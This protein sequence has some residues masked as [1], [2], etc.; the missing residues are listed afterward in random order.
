[1]H[2]FYLLGSS[3]IQSYLRGSKELLSKEDY[4][5][6]Q[7]A[8]QELTKAGGKSMLRPFLE[9]VK[10]QRKNVIY[11]AEALHTLSL[12]SLNKLHDFFQ[13]FNVTIVMFYRD[14]LS[15][16]VSLYNHQCRKFNCSRSILPF[17]SENLPRAKYKMYGTIERYTKIFSAQSIRLIDYHGVVATGKD[18][19][20]VMVCEILS[21][22]CDDAGRLNY[23]GATRVNEAVNITS[24]ALF[25]EILSIGQ[26]RCSCGVGSADMSPLAARPTRKELHG[27]GAVGQPNGDVDIASDVGKLFQSIQED[28]RSAPFT[29]LTNTSLSVH[30]KYASEADAEIRKRY[31]AMMLYCNASANAEARSRIATQEELNITSLLGNPAAVKWLEKQAEKLT[32]QGCQRIC[33]TV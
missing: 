14:I 4:L 27:V 7:H 18:V 25:R 3:H 13:D 6:T 8:Y 11:S 17:L 10:S 21:I 30:Q 28:L 2:L 23:G 19:A 5:Q 16:E 24:H 9:H 32:Q 15:R 22:L 26:V 33:T 31:G 12:R 1:M 29:A 20:Y